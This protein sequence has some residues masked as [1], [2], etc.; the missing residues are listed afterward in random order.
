[1]ELARGNPGGS[2][3]QARPFVVASSSRIYKLWCCPRNRC[4]LRRRNASPFDS[5]IS[6]YGLWAGVLGSPLGKAVPHGPGFRGRMPRFGRRSGTAPIGLLVKDSRMLALARGEGQ[7]IIIDG[8]IEV[9]IVKWSRSSVRIA[10]Q[11]REVSVVR[12]AIWRRCLRRLIS[13]GEGSRRRNCSPGAG[14]P[15]RR[16]V[17]CQQIAGACRHAV[18]GGRSVRHFPSGG[19]GRYAYAGLVRGR[20]GRGGRK[21][22]HLQRHDRENR[23][24]RRSARRNRWRYSHKA[25]R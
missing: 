18:A 10:I 17:Y 6:M 15:L 2:C 16:F 12:D 20:R 5:E 9:K 8:H 22:A 19:G 23:W 1:M 7:S 11:A 3:A 14:G 4:I 21:C 13:A 25:R 24:W